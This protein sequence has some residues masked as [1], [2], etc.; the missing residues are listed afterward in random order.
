MAANLGIA[1]LEKNFSS[2]LLQSFETQQQ[3]LLKVKNFLNDGGS[4]SLKPRLLVIQCNFDKKYD[5]DLLSCARYTIVEQFKEFS[6]N[7]AESEQA[8][9][10]FIMLLI[11]LAKEN[12][13]K[14]IGFQVSHWACYHVDDLDESNNYLPSLEAM[15]SKSLSE[16]L[17][18]GLEVPNINVTPTDED[19]IEVDIDSAALRV[20]NL[21]H[22]FKKIAH[23]ACSLILDTNLERTIERIELFVNFCDDETFLKT[24]T[25]RMVDLQKEKESTLSTYENARN[26]LCKEVADLKNINEFSTLKRSCQ[27]YIE[28][29]LSTLLAFLLAKID[30]FSNLDIFEESIPWKCDLFVQILEKN[31]FLPIYISEMRDEVRNVE[32]KQFVCNSA[33]FKKNFKDQTTLSLTECKLRPCLPFFW[34]LINQLNDFCK[35]YIES[36]G[37]KQKAEGYLKTIPGFFENTPIYRVFSAS[38]KKYNLN[39]IEFLDNYINDFVLVNCPNV[40]LDAEMKIIKTLIKNSI[41]EKRAELEQNHALSSLKVSL[42]L[43]HFIYEKLRVKIEVYSKFSLIDSK[44]NDE[45]IKNNRI[46]TSIDLNACMCAI[47]LFE[48]PVANNFN[49]F[50]MKN[51]LDVLIKTV[52][53]ALTVFMS[54]T[55]Y[56]WNLSNSVKLNQIV[57]QYNSLLFFSLFLG[58]VVLN[59]NYKLHGQEIIFHPL[60]NLF[61]EKLNKCALDFKS[62]SYIE[63]VHEF[64]TKCIYHARVALF[65]YNQTAK[66]CNRPSTS[67]RQMFPFVCDCLICDNC[68]LYMRQH[69]KNGKV[70]CKSCKREIECE[71]PFCTKLEEIP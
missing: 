61:K 10:N 19:D 21:K 40:R 49:F 30:F 68:E 62:N 47:R 32:L 6:R 25:K 51:R 46:S 17:S 57:S 43:V 14:F 41:G 58:N 3:F 9:N 71:V 55:N 56:I 34:I 4:G 22:F 54:Q 69:M 2:C 11:T 26:W 8:N 36:G 27:N 63:F 1:D 50:E 18:D 44:V 16:I 53:A 23:Q 35:T 60:C 7:N 31:D 64:L 33:R 12:S 67:F 52:R 38:I 66:C 13:K 65:E 28:I 29:K 59:K 39:E 37:E 45:L 70:I 15:K 5:D 20:I 42:P 48:I 24:I